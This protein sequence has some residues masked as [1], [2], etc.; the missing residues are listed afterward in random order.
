MAAELADLRKQLAKQKRMTEILKKLS[1]TSEVDPKKWTSGLV[2]SMIRKSTNETNMQNI[3]SRDKILHRP[4][5]DEGRK[6][7]Q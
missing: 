1:A 7:D 2:G 3:H 5:G 4:R 6:D